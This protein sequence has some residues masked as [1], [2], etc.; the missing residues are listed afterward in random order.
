MVK[1]FLQRCNHISPNTVSPGRNIPEPSTH[2]EYGSLAVLYGIVS[3]YPGDPICIG[4]TGIFAMN[5][6][7][8]DVPGSRI[9]QYDGELPY[10]TRSRRSVLPST[11]GRE[12]CGCIDEN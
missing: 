8:A 12:I 10:K 6:W 3:M 7:G 1:G 9:E 4:L 2:E 5:R 11:Y